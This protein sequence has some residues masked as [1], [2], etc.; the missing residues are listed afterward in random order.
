MNVIYVPDTRLKQISSP[1][2]VI[3]EE[4]HSL[5]DTMLDVMYRDEGCGLA[6]IQ[7]GI[8]KRLI[9][10]DF[11]EDDEEM[12]AGGP[13]FMINP[14]ITWTSEEQVT[15]REGCLSIPGVAVDVT[16]PVR[17]RIAFTNRKGAREEHEAGGYLG[18]CF[19]HEIDH[20]N[21][22]TS[23]DRVSALKRKMLL[24]KSRRY[25]RTMCEE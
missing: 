1:V 9:V 16:R 12:P 22:L 18:R 20:L 13:L 11:G 5:L 25:Q 2:E 21:G 6:A 15:L 17:A 23:L 24:N 7:L 8:P 10:I 4:V 14:E 3:N 19:L